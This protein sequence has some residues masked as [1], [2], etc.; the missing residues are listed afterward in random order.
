MVVQ[1]FETPMLEMIKDEYN[2]EYN[3]EILT[4]TVLVVVNRIVF[5][6]DTSYILNRI[7]Y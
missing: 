2:D 6:I 1:D 7:T 3:D 5:E 4:K